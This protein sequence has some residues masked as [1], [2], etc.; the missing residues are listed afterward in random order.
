MYKVIRNYCNCHP[1]TCA[2]N[3]WVIVNKEGVYGT[4]FSKQTA[5]DICTLLN[6]RER[7]SKDNEK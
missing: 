7:R 6:E 2:C 5:E 4:F 3:D 1:E